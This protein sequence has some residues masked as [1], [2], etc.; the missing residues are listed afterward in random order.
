MLAPTPSLGDTLIMDNLPAHKVADARAAI[1]TMGACL[2]LP[3]P[4]SPVCN[5]IE[6]AFAKLKALLRQ[7]AARTIPELWDTVGD[8]L[9]GA[10]CTLTAVEMRLD[11]T[12]VD[13]LRAQPLDA[14]RC[15]SLDS[16]WPGGT[17]P[18]L[19]I[20]NTQDVVAPPENSRSLQRDFPD[21]VTL[22][23]LPNAGHRMV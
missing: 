1:E 7:A 5:P 22:P 21:R 13:A 19:V 20:Q 15:G 8:A 10:A 9:F 16:W 6:L 12:A 18:T 23:E 2:R 11:D 14:A 4:C 3:P 17:T